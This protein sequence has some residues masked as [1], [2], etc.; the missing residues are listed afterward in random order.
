MRFRTKL[1]VTSSAVILLLWAATLWPI[2]KTISSSFD[3]LA[4][5]NFTGTRQSLHTLQVE[6]VSR[7]RQAGRMLMEIPE[8]RALIAEQN[9]ELSPENLESLKERL[10]NLADVMSVEFVCV[11]NGQGQLIAQNSKSPWPS[12]TDLGT[13]V[14]GSPQAQPLARRLFADKPSS[15]GEYGLWVYQNRLYQVVGL[16]LVFSA[17]GSRPDGALIMATLMTNDLAAG[18]S[19][20][21]GC[22]V[23]FLAD[24]K[25]LASSLSPGAQAELLRA[26]RKDRWPDSQS[27]DLKLGGRNYCSFVEPLIDPGSGLR[28]GSTVIQ[29]DTTDGQT[30]LLSVSHSLLAIASIG[31][32]AAA[33]LSFFLSG[34]VTRPVNELVQGVSRVAGGNLNSLI[35]VRRGDEL[36]ELAA[37]FNEMVVQL[38][39]RAE[40]QRQVDESRAANQAKSQFL[41]NMS[42]EIRTPLHGVMGMTNLLLSTE[43]NARQRHYA[44]LVRSSTE[45]LTTLINDILD[46]SK[47]EAGKM[48][49]ESVEFDVRAV[50]EDVVE[51]L[52]QR[53]FAKGLEITADIAAD[54]PAAVRGDSNRVRQVLMNLIGNAVKFTE[55]GEIIVSMAT[56]AD[57]LRFSISDTGIGIP[58]DRLERLF[59]SFSQMD[60]STTRRYGG[61][62]LGLAISKQLVQLMG[63]EISVESQSGRG[64]TFSFTV[65]FE[66]V[67]A[68]AP[69]QPH[70][71]GVRVLVAEDNISIRQIIMRQLTDAGIEAVGVATAAEAVNAENAFG[72]L[73]VD[74]RLAGGLR[75]H[76]GPTARVLI[77][78]ADNSSI[79]GF[80]ATVFKPLRRSQLL[81]AV[82]AAMGREVQIAT[83]GAAEKIDKSQR[84]ARILIAEDNE[85]NQLL[86]GEVLEQAGHQ[87]HVVGDGQS[88][89]R[90]FAEGRFDL[91]LMDCQMPV[92]DGCDAARAIRRLERERSAL[93]PIPIIALTANASGAD[94][95]RCIEA[96]MNAYLEKPFKTR[97]LA[98]LIESLLSDKPPDAL[99][100]DAD[101]TE[102]WPLDARRLL[103]NCTGNA[104]LAMKVLDKFHAQVNR[105]LE[106]IAQCVAERD[107]QRL[108][109]A[110]HAM[111]GAAGAVS[112]ESLRQAVARMEEIGRS[113]ALDAA[114]ECFARLRDEVARCLAFLPRV[115]EELHANPIG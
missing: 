20:A 109:R 85:V 65:R 11:L 58:S 89:V 82:S 76:S 30:L 81:A 41:A 78:T 39:A 79:A 100:E 8:L 19:E 22:D 110:A 51:L 38:R 105:A 43:L 67:V 14:S 84:P 66:S 91:I 36:G 53:A 77:T 9:F 48:E 28:I 101:D 32:I 55:S 108:A 35:P 18:L 62:G 95:K 69:A 111:K 13:Y 64:S 31:L 102:A 63:G 114:E 98:A 3:R 96:G 99:P 40:L 93:R 71:S 54:V 7:M 2:Q 33:L 73:L 70:F 86:A 94:R 29:N 24:D 34:A 61:T 113:D 83:G 90:A 87:S 104:D 27:F 45:V 23:S 72:V 80:A 6:R 26:R 16:P 52:S 60:A 37:A 49:L 46:F 42:H 5:A 17:D 68:S 115:R 1:F 59:Q 12:L 21:N 112:A 4:N 25:A 103:E 75:S 10:D 106:Q 44:T 88:A 92:M 50:V 57:R 56:A 47:I 97:E 74:S 107:G 15:D